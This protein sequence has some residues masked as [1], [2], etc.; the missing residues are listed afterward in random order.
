MSTWLDKAN[1]YLWLASLNM[2]L[3]CK[4]LQ[5]HFIKVCTFLSYSKVWKSSGFWTGNISKDGNSNFEWARS[6]HWPGHATLQH[7]SCSTFSRDSGS[8]VALTCIDQSCITAPMCQCRHRIQWTMKELNL[9][10]DSTSALGSSHSC[11]KCKSS[12]AANHGFP[13]SK[14]TATL[15]HKRWRKRT[16]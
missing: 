16:D 1:I 14:F 10:A 9:H 7:T 13:F 6:S 2:T 3:Y 11:A 15:K 4:F 12:G 8:R 5:E